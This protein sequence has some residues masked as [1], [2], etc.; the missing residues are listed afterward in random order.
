MALST[1]TLSITALCAVC[2]Y[3]ACRDLFIVMLNV[4]MF[5]VG[6]L[7]VVAPHYGPYKL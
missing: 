5:S 6:M 1:M 3:A 4:V 2:H 7:N